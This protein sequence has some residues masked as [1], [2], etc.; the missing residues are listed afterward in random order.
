MRRPP[1]CRTIVAALLSAATAHVGAQSTDSARVSGRRLI[2]VFDGATGAPIPGVQVRDGFSDSSVFTNADGISPLSWLSYRGMAGM[3]EL[4]KL[5]YDPKR[6]FV[7]RDDTVSLTVTLD[8]IATL[9]P[10]ITAE[11]Y[12]IDRDEGRWSGFEARCQTGSAT[13]FRAEDLAKY[14]AA[15]LADVIIK[16]RGVT[17]G[18]CGGPSDRQTECGR[19]AM[20][21]IVIPPA[22]CQPTFFVDGFE[23]GSRAWLPSDVVPGRAPEAPL[24]PSNVKAI[25]VYPPERNRPLRF[26]GNPQ[27]GA[28]VI[29]TK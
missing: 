11:R 29:W 10:V 26:A 24:I 12:R 27:C 20:R 19:I 25:E 28:V 14:G 16:A 18:A 1:L 2:G 3:V 13:C 22:F 5:G 23:W 17:I 6:I 9:A 4:R 7:N 8:R 21:S 15:N